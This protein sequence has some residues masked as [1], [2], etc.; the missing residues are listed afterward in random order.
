MQNYTISHIRK[1]RNAIGAAI[2]TVDGRKGIITSTNS[3]LCDY[4]H[5]YQVT[6]E[7]GTQN[8]LTQHDFYIDI[9]VEVGK[10]YMIMTGEIITAHKWEF[11]HSDDLFYFKYNEHWGADNIHT[12]T[13]KSNGW[14]YHYDC[15]CNLLKEIK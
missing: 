9:K 6:W 3:T 15:G 11:S 8:E 2:I 4:P 5:L 12:E 10:R 13:I 7:D 14:T 1:P